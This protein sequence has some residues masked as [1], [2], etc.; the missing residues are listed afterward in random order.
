MIATPFNRRG[1]Q[2]QRKV[3]ARVGFYPARDWVWTGCGPSDPV[4]ELRDGFSLRKWFDPRVLIDVFSH[5][6]VARQHARE[7]V[8]ASG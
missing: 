3:R 4:A 8:W 2:A 1:V 6:V 5:R 7:I